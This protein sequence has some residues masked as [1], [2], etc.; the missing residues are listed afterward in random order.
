[1]AEPQH[2]IIEMSEEY[3]RRQQYTAFVWVPHVP[4]YDSGASPSVVK[5]M[6][7][8]CNLTGFDSPTMEIKNER[9]ITGQG[10]SEKTI[11]DGY[12]VGEFTARLQANGIV[13]IA[14]MNGQNMLKVGEFAYKQRGQTASKGSLIIMGYDMNSNGTGTATIK[15]V[16]VFDQLT[17]KVTGLGSGDNDAE[18]DISFMGDNCTPQDFI[19]PIIPGVEI[20]LTGVGTIVNANAII[21]AG[22]TITL[23]TGNGSLLAATTDLSATDND[24]SYGATDARRYLIGAIQN[25]ERLDLSAM[26]YTQGVAAT[27]EATVTLPG[28]V[29]NAAGDYLILLYAVDTSGGTGYTDRTAPGYR[30]DLGNAPKNVRGSWKQPFKRFVNG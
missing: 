10:K 26:V 18:I 21:S 16:T 24:D 29:E 30:D 15:R 3:N 8:V 11:N 4:L 12:R 22:G 27:S 19:G 5:P 9:Q 2:T 25:Q 1:M 17:M 14:A 20:F 13:S 6:A 28:A 23:G 7:V